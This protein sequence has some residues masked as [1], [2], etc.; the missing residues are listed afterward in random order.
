MN[1]TY[2]A[3]DAAQTA[4]ERIYELV[5]EFPDPGVGV[6]EYERDFIDALN[7]DIDMPKALSIMWELLRSKESNENKAAALYE[8]DK[9][10]GLNIYAHSQALKDIPDEILQMADERDQLRRHKKYLQ[11]DQM[12]IKIEKRGY[13]VK[14]GDKHAKVLKK[15]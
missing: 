2:E 1:F 12:R 10:L 15:I 6:I 13:I 7:N 14:D 9:V 8:M 5:S 4:L 11:A 3:L